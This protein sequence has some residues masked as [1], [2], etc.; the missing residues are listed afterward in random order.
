[1]NMEVVPKKT[2][3]TKE[4]S[5]LHVQLI[6]TK[7]VFEIS[8]ALSKSLTNSLKRNILP[9]YSRNYNLNFNVLVLPIIL[10]LLYLKCKIFC[11]CIYYSFYTIKLLFFVSR[12]WLVIIY[13]DCKY[14]SAIVYLINFKKLNNNNNNYRLVT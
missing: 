2:P 10:F 13:W 6:K 8:I 1:M 12:F 14:I 9:V 4:N 5:S 11:F 7:I 3:A